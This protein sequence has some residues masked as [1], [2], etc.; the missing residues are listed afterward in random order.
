MSFNVIVTIV[1]ML[2]V[3]ILLVWN[4]VHPG[5][6]LGGVPIAAAF[7]MGF[8]VDEIQGFVNSGFGVIVGTLC[9]MIFA[10]LYFGIL[11]ELGVFK[12]LV[13]K[14]MGLLKNSVF[15]VM[16]ATALITIL[17]QLDGSGSTTALCTIP[18]MAPVYE[19]MKIR[20]DA[21]VFIEGLGSGIFTFLPWAPAVN[22][23]S[24]Y[25]GL[26]AYDVYNWLIPVALFAV[27][28]YFVIL[29]P[30]SIIEKRHGAGMTAEEYAEMRKDIMKPVELPYGKPLAIFATILTVAIMILL[31]VGILPITLTF[32][33]GYAV[34]M[35]LTYKNPKNMGGYLGRQA[36]MILSLTMTML[37]VAI[38]V[39]VNNGTGALA[40]AAELIASSGGGFVKHLPWICC[41]LSLPLSFVTGNAKMSVVI[42]AVAA[43]AAPFGI[44]PEAVC[45]GILFCGAIGASVNVFSGSCYLAVNLAGIEIRDH[46]KYSLIPYFFFSIALALFIGVTGMIPF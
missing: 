46:I 14:I 23:A 27:V 3:L 26:E 42:P 18:P 19:K 35:V 12:W 21:L 13:N 29:F 31:L 37:G 5:I 1:M 11:H 40:E 45:G 2:A 24:A 6:V 22:E 8:S 38:L 9:I 10:I 15:G 44:A 39:G 33:V 4:K 17:T 43:V 32:V 25:L 34:L 41:A 20:K 16:V 36:P 30:L 7:I 28:L